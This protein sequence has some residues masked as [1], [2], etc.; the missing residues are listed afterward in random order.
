MKVA[1][2]NTRPN[3]SRRIAL[4]EHTADIL[5]AIHYYLNSYSILNTPFFSSTAIDGTTNYEARYTHS[6]IMNMRRLMNQQ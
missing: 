1:N 2:G 3:Y 6:I 5:T 4:I